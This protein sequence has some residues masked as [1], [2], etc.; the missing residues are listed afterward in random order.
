MPPPFSQIFESKAFANLLAGQ[1]RRRVEDIDKI[2]ECL[3]AVLQS[4]HCLFC[5]YSIGELHAQTELLP[6]AGIGI[7]SFVYTALSNGVSGQLVSIGMERRIVLAPVF[8]LKQIL[9]IHLRR[10]VSFLDN[11]HDKSPYAT[12][13][14]VSCETF[15]LFDDFLNF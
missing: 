4:I 6:S 13:F 12:F 10:N 2:L 14:F 8:H 9:A 1:V 7:V 5:L 3:C 11:F 15:V